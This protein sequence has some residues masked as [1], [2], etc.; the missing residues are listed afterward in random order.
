MIKFNYLMAFLAFG[1]TVT[2]QT[3]SNNVAKG[4]I[5][6]ADE[7]N[8]KGLPDPKKW[9]YEEGFIRNREKQYYT[10]ARAENS[11]VKDG[12]LIITSLKEKYRD[13]EYTSASINTLGKQSFAGDI[14]VEVRAKLPSGKGIWP[15]IWMMGDN[16]QQVGWPKCAEFD[17]MEFVGH[18]PNTVHANLHW[19]DTLT[20]GHAAKGAQTTRQDLHTAFHTYGLE[21]KGDSIR[22]FVD[23][24]YFFS[25]KGADNA[26]KSSFTDP[27]YLLL[28][29]AVGG[30]WGGDIDDTIFPQRYF[31]DYVRVFRLQ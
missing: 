24:E 17:I 10:R 29:T 19:Y 2:A 25:M 30:E 8:Y 13:A 20:S 6:W 5:V 14:R 9:S 26:L 28:N 15:A 18:T 11:Y 7:F 21:R 16:V 31:I 1:F 22:I 12:S 4:T 27:L 23:D 3:K